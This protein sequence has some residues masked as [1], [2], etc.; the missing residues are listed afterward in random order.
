MTKI[1]SW[2]WSVEILLVWKEKS[3]FLLDFIFS[4][5]R[6]SDNRQ[7]MTH[8]FMP[9][10]F[11]YSSLISNSILSK[12]SV[13]NRL[14]NRLL[15]NSTLD[16]VRFRL[17]NLFRDISW[18]KFKKLLADSTSIYKWR[19]SLF[20]NH[21]KKKRI[22]NATTFELTRFRTNQKTKKKHFNKIWTTRIYLHV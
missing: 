3:R 10:N 17:L 2:E 5:N 7:W 19:V 20:S 9:G 14:F 6:L 12:F 15:S 21:S 11:L 1:I 8:L 4:S 13:K 18:Q 16:K 22:R